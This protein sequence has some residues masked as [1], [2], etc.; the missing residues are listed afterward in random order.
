MA[1][2]TLR[3]L[4]LVAGMGIAI[5][6]VLVG[7]GVAQ[8]HAGGGFLSG[9]ALMD[10]LRF[11]V[12]AA[13]IIT[14]AGVVLVLLS[15]FFPAQRSGLPDES[16]SPESP[17]DDEVEEPGPPASEA[18]PRRPYGIRLAH[19]LGVDA[20]ALEDARHP[21]PSPMPFWT[22]MQTFVRHGPKPLS[23]IRLLLSR[24]HRAVH[25]EETKQGGC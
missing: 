5:P 10:C 17:P 3:R 4:L 2:F 19:F 22:S 6:L 23:L 11:V 1:M 24:I 18:A 8:C 16:F 12:A 21:A 15:R 7:M 20:S 25:G 13:A 9:T 14:C